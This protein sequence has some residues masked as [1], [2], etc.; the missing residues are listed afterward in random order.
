MSQG[1]SSQLRSHGPA[2]D[3]DRGI[4]TGQAVT[5]F[6]HAPRRTLADGLAQLPWSNVCLAARGFAGGISRYGQLGIP[7]GAALL[8][9]RDG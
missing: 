4:L 1:R 3:L 2:D 8:F 9:I 5:G 7:I 6:P